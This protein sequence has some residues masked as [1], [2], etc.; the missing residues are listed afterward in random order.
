MSQLSC[1]RYSGLV[2]L[3]EKNLSIMGKALE[4]L[5]KRWPS[6]VGSL[7]HLLDVRE[8]VMQRPSLGLFPDLNM[9]PTTAQFFSEFGPDLCRMWHPIHAEFPQ[10]AN[11]APRELET[12]GILQHLRTPAITPADLNDASSAAMQ[13]PIANSHAIAGGGSLEPTLLQPQEWF[14]P[15]GAGGLGNWLMIDWDQAFG[16]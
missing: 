8:K 15:Y 6:A 10:L 7:K 9:T 16:W 11:I 5:G 14:V 13:Q 12:A 2:N 4:E 3:A 1:Y